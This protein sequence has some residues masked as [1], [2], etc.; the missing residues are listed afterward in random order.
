MSNPLNLA[1]SDLLY[2]LGKVSHPDLIAVR[3]V[4]NLYGLL[5]DAEA[6]L[7]IPILLQEPSKV[8]HN[9]RRGNPHLQSCLIRLLSLFKAAKILQQINQQRPCSYI[10]AQCTLLLVFLEELLPFGGL[11]AGETHNLDGAVYVVVA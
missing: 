8:E 1:A 7:L 6:L 2:D 11:G 3:P 10:I 5:I 9:L 4:E